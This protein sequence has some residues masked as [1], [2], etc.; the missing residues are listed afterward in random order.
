MIGRKSLRI[1]LATMLTVLM[2]LVS[3]LPVVAEGNPPVTSLA[4]LE[5][6]YPMSA[7]AEAAIVHEIPPVPVIID[8]IKYEPKEAA[9][10][11]GQ[12]LR[13]TPGMDGQLY[14]FTTVEG[15]ETFLREQREQ[16]GRNYGGYVPSS[17]LTVGSTLFQ[18]YWFSGASV[19]LVVNQGDDDL[20][21]LNN[22]ISSLENWGEPLEYETTLFDYTDYGGD[23]ATFPL[24]GGTEFY[25]YWELSSYG[26]N[27][28]AES[29]ICFVQ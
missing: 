22:Q 29:A 18:Y 27:D 10:F 1:V 9:L 26:W 8:G 24:P 25:W 15:L 21:N 13:F 4:E 11:N 7:E 14:A 28:R 23:Y 5:R 2:V 19:D 16:S 17:V 20:G 12:R 6:L 3:A